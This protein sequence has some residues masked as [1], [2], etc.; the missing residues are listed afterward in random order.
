MNNPTIEELKNSDKYE[1]VYE[2]KH[3]QVK[4]FVISQISKGS[5]LIQVFMIY[6]FI[7][8]FIGL[9]FVTRPVVLSFGGNLQPLLYL[10]IAL[11]FSFSI[12][13]LIHEMLHALAFKITGAPR[14]SIG[15]Y[16]KKLIFYAQA[17]RHV[18]NKRQFVFVALVPFIVV[19]LTTFAGV[20]FSWNHPAAYFW[21]F[22]MCA[23]SLFCAGDIAMLDYLY[24]FS[25]S[26][27]YTFDVKEEKISYFYRQ[28][29]SNI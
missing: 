11:V 29:I 17:D 28:R 5:R 15:S 24:K 10:L 2:L 9:F 14:V 8:I 1:L 19:K 13:I 3:H 20:A 7:M 21:I 16:L 23:H 26:E 18:L 12:L 25:D 6:Q 4:D 22:I 27:L